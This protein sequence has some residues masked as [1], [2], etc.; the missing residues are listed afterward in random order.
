VKCP[1]RLVCV[2]PIT[3]VLS[4]APCPTA[5][6]Q[7]SK[8]SVGTRGLQLKQL[9]VA[10]GY[11]GFHHR[12]SATSRHRPHARGRAR[13]WDSRAIVCGSRQPG[14]VRTRGGKRGDRHRTGGGW[15]RR[16]PVCTKPQ[17]SSRPARATRKC[18]KNKRSP[19]GTALLRGLCAVRPSRNPSTKVP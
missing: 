19:R 7:L 10:R 3:L 1:V 9:G 11:G 13:C 5:K 4:R 16:P 6:A 18:L 17:T 12:V 15:A 8:T 14:S 2:A